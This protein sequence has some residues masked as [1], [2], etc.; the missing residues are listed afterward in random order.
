MG[1]DGILGDGGK[2]SDT[3]FWAAVRS[4][5]CG[6]SPDASKLVQRREDVGLGARAAARLFIAPARQEQRSWRPFHTRAVR[7]C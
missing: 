4:R 1:R 6:L 7:Q 3:K 2:L 5:A